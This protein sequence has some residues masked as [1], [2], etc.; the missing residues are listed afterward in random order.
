L[1]GVGLW[2]DGELIGLEDEKRLLY[3]LKSTAD[4][5]VLDT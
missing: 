3:N 1:D 4:D 2:V 5:E